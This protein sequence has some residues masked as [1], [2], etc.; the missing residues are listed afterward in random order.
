MWEESFNKIVSKID[1]QEGAN[2]H[3]VTINSEFFTNDDFLRRE[4]SCSNGLGITL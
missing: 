4:G 1:L 3:Y 2:N